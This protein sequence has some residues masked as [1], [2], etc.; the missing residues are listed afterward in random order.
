MTKN[1]QSI[2]DNGKE[3]IRKYSEHKIAAHITHNLKHK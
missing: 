2:V 3:V 1:A